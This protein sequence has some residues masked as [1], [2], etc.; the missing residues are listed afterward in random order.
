MSLALDRIF[1]REEAKRLTDGA[2]NL[3]NLSAFMLVPFQVRKLKS[4]AVAWINRRW[5]LERGFD[6]SDPSVAAR[7]Q[8]WL[9]EE[10]AFLASDPAGGNAVATDLDRTFFADRYGSTEGMSPH[11]GSGRVAT[12]GQFQVKGIGITPLVG[13]GGQPGHAHGCC[14]LAEC[15][16]EAIYSEIMAAVLP[17]GAVPVIAIID[18]GLYYS[19]PDRSERFDQNVRR[20]LLV[21]PSVLRLAHIERAPMF[22]ASLRGYVNVQ[23]DDTRRAGDI[24][25]AWG[26]GKLVFSGRHV[27]SLSRLMQ[28]LASQLAF[29]HV[30]RLF[31]GGFFSSNLSVFGEFIDFGN[32][33]VFPN[34]ASAHVLGHG[35]PFGSEMANLMQVV[36][37]LAFFMNK[38]NAPR[39]KED[40]AALGAILR[41]TY[42]Q[43]LDAEILKLLDVNAAPPYGPNCRSL[44]E[45]MRQ[46]IKEERRVHVHYV[47]G[48][49]STGSPR[50]LTNRVFDEI[51]RYLKEGDAPS[52]GIARAV[53]AARNESSKGAVR[54]ESNPDEWMNCLRSLD[55][56]R[57]IDRGA[58]LRETHAMTK[59]MKSSSFSASDRQMLAAFIDS[60][61]GASSG[62]SRQVTCDLIGEAAH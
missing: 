10:F 19:S 29:V 8:H 21:R 48:E 17:H 1:T 25:K 61:I 28:R 42:E 5:F 58:L 11:G 27:P 49:P 51:V 62:Q 4:P 7:V 32:A 30:H 37:S 46:V 38:Y 9:I 31:N 43:C 23:Y 6:L 39:I 52:S 18:T 36:H 40:P 33:H 15:I 22:R 47:H 53:V 20:G 59:A 35:A 56:R 13:A 41:K 3:G 60:K 55:Y 57:E 24:A 16:R 34:W 2:P 50:N 54:R 14:S 26:D 44:I 12:V 45:R